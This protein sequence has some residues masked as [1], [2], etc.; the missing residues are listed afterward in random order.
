MADE[1]TTATATTTNNN[2]TSSKGNNNKKQ[3]LSIPPDGYVCKLCQIKGHWIQQCPKRKKKNSKKKNSGHVPIPGVDPSPDDIE[4]AK[5]L[6]KLKPPVCFCRLPSRLKKVKRSF[7]AAAADNNNGATNKH[8][9]AEPDYES[10]RAIGKYFFFC[11]KKRDD[12]SKCRFARPVEDHEDITPKSQRPCAFW[13]KTGRCK[14]GDSCAFRHEGDNN[15]TD[16]R[17]G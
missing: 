17:N 5:A 7:A 15:T 3:K 4:K 11:S 2:N 10:S 6:Q 12:P 13:A 14:K 9:Y 16:G 8:S 1:T